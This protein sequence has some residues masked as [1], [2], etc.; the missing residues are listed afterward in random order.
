[1]KYS[2]SVVKD[3]HPAIYMVAMITT[4][5]GTYILLIRPHVEEAYTLTN[6][7]SVCEWHWWGQLGGVQTLIQTWISSHVNIVTSRDFSDTPMQLWIVRITHNQCHTQWWQTVTYTLKK[8]DT[9]QLHNMT[10]WHS[11]TIWHSDTCSA[12]PPAGVTALEKPSI[13]PTGETPGYD[14]AEAW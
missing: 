13:A 3:L 2:A 10:Q 6:V 7:S 9:L 12:T 8:Y 11:D 4:V 14:K 1:M 5:G